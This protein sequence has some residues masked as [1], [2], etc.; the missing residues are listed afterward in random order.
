MRLLNGDV[1]GEAV[2][3]FGVPPDAAASEPNTRPEAPLGGGEPA[4]V[5]DPEL[6]PADAASPLFAVAPE[7]EADPWVPGLEPIPSPALRSPALLELPAVPD[8]EIDSRDGRFPLGA[9]PVWNGAAI[10][11]DAVESATEPA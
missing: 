1:T 9:R 2:L 8:R 6:K 3:S 11:P 7:V 5:I 10:V 4:P